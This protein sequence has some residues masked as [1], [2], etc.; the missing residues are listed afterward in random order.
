MKINDVSILTG[1]TK[2]AIKYYEQKG[3]LQILKNEN[4]YRNYCME[5]VERL[6]EIA[7]YRKLEISLSDI[8]QLLCN[9]DQKAMLLTSIYE[10][11][12]SALKET[13][14]VLSQLKALIHSDLTTDTITNMEKN[15]EYITIASALQ[16][17]LP[18]YLGQYF[19]Q[20]FLPYLQ[21]PMTTPEQKEAYDKILVFLDEL[22]LKPTW[23]MRCSSYLLRHAH[24]NIDRMHYIVDQQIKE[25]L[26]ADDEAY[27]AYKAKIIH[28]VKQRQRWCYRWNPIAISNRTFM[29]RLQDCGFYD[30]LI[31]NMK[32]LSP[33]YKDYHD[34]L[35]QLNERICQ[36]TGIHYDSHCHLV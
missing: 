2:R 29:K 17:M 23:V 30:I 13:S 6:K 4:G 18:G 3:L 19:M 7:L 12:L 22:D 33:L 14:C 5:D 26:S 21:I 24:Q 1:M 28:Q 20:H 10:Q 27:E 35:L 25:M 36:D 34:T 32:R 15:M 16:D 11:K 9:P 8:K 31:P